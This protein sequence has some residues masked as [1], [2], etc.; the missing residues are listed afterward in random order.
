MML[1][2]VDGCSSTCT[3]SELSI[4]QDNERLQSQLDN[5]EGAATNQQVLDELHGLEAEERVLMQKVTFAARIYAVFDKMLR[6]L[7]RLD[8]T[9]VT[10]RILLICGN[11]CA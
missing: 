6:R 10:I 5:L 2:I 9:Y 8:A 11:A 3:D 4:M 7:Q 1:S